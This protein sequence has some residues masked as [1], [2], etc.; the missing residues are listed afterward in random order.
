MFVGELTNNKERVA[1]LLTNLATRQRGPELLL[2]AFVEP[3]A[4]T[5][6][7]RR[8]A[9]RAGVRAYWYA[10]LAAGAGVLLALSAALLGRFL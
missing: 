7:S 8:A 9:G 5:G 4:L 10:A 3:G 2:G 6:L 1:T